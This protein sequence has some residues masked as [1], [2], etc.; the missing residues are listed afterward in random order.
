MDYMDTEAMGAILK[1]EGDVLAITAKEPSDL[2]TFIMPTNGKLSNWTWV[3]FSNSMGKISCNASS[4][5]LFNIFNKMNSNLAYF[6]VSHNLEILHLNNSNEFENEINKQ[7]EKEI[8][9][10]E[11]IL[12]TINESSKTCKNT[13]ERLDPQITT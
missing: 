9:P 13:F 8:E 7:L 1:M 3:G 4:N 5:I 11:P 10:M 6:D 12:E 2:S